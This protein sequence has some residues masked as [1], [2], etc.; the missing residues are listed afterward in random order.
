MEIV[1]SDG[2][3]QAEQQ[4]DQLVMQPITELA[5]NE[6]AVY[7]LTAKGTRAGDHVLRVQLVSDEFSTPVTKEEIT[8]VYS[9]K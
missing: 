4:G 1:D 2:P 8:K 7:R 9:D 6:E 3:T 5:Q